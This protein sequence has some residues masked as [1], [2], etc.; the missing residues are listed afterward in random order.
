[1][2]MADSFLV[3]RLPRFVA[4]PRVAFA[5]VLSLAMVSYLHFQKARG[6]YFA[7]FICKK[8]GAREFSD[9]R[10]RTRAIGPGARLNKQTLD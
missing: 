7:Q 9:M 10:V 6:K 3:P 4:V 1:M 8:L 2:L 5:L